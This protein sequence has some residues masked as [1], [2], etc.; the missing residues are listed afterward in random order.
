MNYKRNNKKLP[1]A[2]SHFAAFIY[3]EFMRSIVDWSRTF[4]MIDLYPDNSIRFIS[5][6]EVKKELNRLSTK[7]IS[8]IKYK[9]NIF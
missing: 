3:K 4:F 9:V 5:E 2:K 1:T 8:K 6:A 7:S